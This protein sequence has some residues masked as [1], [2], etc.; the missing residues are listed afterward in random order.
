MYPVAKQ[1]S[2]RTIGAGHEREC[3][4]DA[5]MRPP[6]PQ[7]SASEY[8]A[9]DLE[10]PAA[11]AESYVRGDRPVTQR[12]SSERQTAYLWERDRGRPRAES[13]PDMRRARPYPSPHDAP[14]QSDEDDDDDDVREDVEGERCDV[15]GC[16]CAPG[17]K[18]VGTPRLRPAF[19]DT[20]V[21][22]SVAGWTVLEGASEDG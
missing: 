15:P 6:S 22:P 10:A 12:V 21:H 18:G 14:E 4:G 16:D 1:S 3:D 7:W 20:R 11:Q 8:E 13:S 17:R 9:D 2:V 5:V 19:Q